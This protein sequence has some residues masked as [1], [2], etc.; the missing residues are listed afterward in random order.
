M[1]SHVCGCL[2]KLGYKGKRT[3]LLNPLSETYSMVKRMDMEECEQPYTHTIKW[4]NV[5]APQK[6]VDSLLY[7][8]YSINTSLNLNL[9]K[10]MEV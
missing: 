8:T 9:S 3:T 5:H 1:L 4:C 7:V 2:N 6:C 10:Y